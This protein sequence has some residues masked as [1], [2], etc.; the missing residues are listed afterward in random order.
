MLVLVDKPTWFTS[1]DVVKKLKKLYAWEKIG[2][3]WTLDPLATGLLLVAIGKDTKKI[4]QLVGLDKVYQATIDFSQDSDT[5]DTDFRSTHQIFPLEGDGILKEWTLVPAPSLTLI[6]EKLKTIIWTHLL[7]LTPFSAKKRK[8]KKLYEY[9]REGE[10]IFIDSPMEV[11]DFTII[12][13]SFPL[14]TLQLHVGSGTYIRSIAHRLGSQFG[15]GG[16]LTALHRSAIG[17]FSLQKK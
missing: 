16:I 15:L 12:D 4:D 2:H 10:P 3:A 1:F 9:A 8:G 5:W 7:P 11:I 13:Y 6:E 14:L 17:P